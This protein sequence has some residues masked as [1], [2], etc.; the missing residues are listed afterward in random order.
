LAAVSLVENLRHEQ[1]NIAFGG[2]FICEKSDNY[3]KKNGR[4]IEKVER[5]W[6]CHTSFDYF[7]SLR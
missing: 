7:D 1:S 4:T 6:G 5:V 2:H 3:S